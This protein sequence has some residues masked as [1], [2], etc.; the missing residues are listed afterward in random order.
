MVRTSATV[1]WTVPSTTGGSP[2]TGYIV[3]A[4]GGGGQACRTT[5]AT[6]CTVTGLVNGAS[7]TFSVVATNSLGAGPASAASNRVRTGRWTE[8]AFSLSSKS[9]IYGDEQAERLSVRVYL[10]YA[11]NMATP[12]GTV[13]IT[14]LSRKLCTIT[15]RS[16]LGSCSLSAK[17]LALGTY[18]L[19]ATYSGNASYLGS[20]KAKKLVVAKT[21]PTATVLKLSAAKVTYGKEHSERLTVTTK[22]LRTGT[23]TG[24]VTIKAGSRLV[25]TITLRNDIGSCKLSAT[26]LAVGTYS[27]VA[28]Y[29]GNAMY[30]PSVATAKLTVVK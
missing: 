6:S 22:S 12:T 14:E 1:S 10:Q 21:R 9:A 24:T 11:K 15:L 26:Q 30:L 29:P 8:V 3:K 7:Y 13:T 16:G 17:E 19:V 25:C 18:H 27:L 28:S 23:P 2:I 20:S 4:S 5:G